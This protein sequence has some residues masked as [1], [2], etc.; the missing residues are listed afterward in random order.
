MAINMVNTKPYGFKSN[1]F[2]RANRSGH[3][4]QGVIVYSSRYLKEYKQS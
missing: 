4:I 3:K 1:I 2:K